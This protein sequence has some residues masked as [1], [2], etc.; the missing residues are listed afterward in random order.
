M[1]IL[2][3]V[4]GIALIIFFFIFARKGG[5]E[6]PENLEERVVEVQK[7][8][9]TLNATVLLK[10][11]V[12]VISN[13]RR[14]KLNF[15]GNPGMTVGGTG[16]ILSGIVGALLA[17]GNDPFEAAVAGAFINGAVGDLIQK[18]RG[19]HFVSSVLINW[20]P[21]VMRNPAFNMGIKAH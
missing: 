7:F 3:I 16:D 18:K 10:G 8:A 2:M 19:D 17:Q 21:H 12:D 5:K 13:G 6:P 4:I 1:S 20:I 11:H 14:A 9:G 15:S